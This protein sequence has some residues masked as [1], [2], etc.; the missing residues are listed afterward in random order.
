MAGLSTGQK[1]KLTITRCRVDKGSGETS[2]LS[3]SGNVF[4]VMIN[5]ASYKRGYSI[6]YSSEECETTVGATA[7]ESNFA[8]M[9]AE[10]VGFE[11][12]I[13]GTG[14][15]GSAPGAPEVKV[16]L[17]Q[18]KDVVYRYQ[19]D[20]HE[21][22]VVQLSWGQLDA[23]PQLFTGRMTTMT[24]DYTMFEPSG[25][26]LRAKVALAFVSY[27][28]RAEAALRANLSSADMSHL[29]RVRAGD[30]LPGLCH[31]LYNDSSLYLRV[32]RE[33]GIASFR[34]LEPGTLLYFPPMP[35][36]ELRRRNAPETT[37]G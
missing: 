7:V 1:Q 2:P 25:A 14:A 6:R 17:E 9:G 16:Q 10:T 30:T 12:I 18:L 29:I 37:G 3:G 34:S 36:G 32:A 31:R 5:P 24:V 20:E 8:S 15:I 21:P 35:K 22:S 26:P 27:R 28:T 19:G 13:D 33:N 4:D 11:L 23:A